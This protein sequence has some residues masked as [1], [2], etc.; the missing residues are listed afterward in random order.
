MNFAALVRLAI[1]VCL[2]VGFA[3]AGAPANALQHN[4]TALVAHEHTFANAL[5]VADNLGREDADGREGSRSSHSHGDND[6][7]MSARLANGPGI[8]AP[9]KGRHSSLYKI[10]GPVTVFGSLERPPKV[11]NP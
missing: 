1:L 3:G 2:I 4:G 5:T 10:I 7:F 9:R 6:K 8:T 11:P